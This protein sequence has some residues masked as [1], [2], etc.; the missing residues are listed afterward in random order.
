MGLSIGSSVSGGVED[1]LYAR[2]WMNETSGQWGMGV[3]IKTRTAYGGY[4]RNI[5]YEDNYFETA[6]VPGGAIHIESGYQSGHGTCAFDDCTDIRDIVF[7]NLTFKKSG[8]TGNFVCFPN[9]PCHNITFDNVHVESATSGWGCND[10]ASGSFTD[11]TPPR[12]PTKG[13]C[14]FTSV[15]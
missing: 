7:R 9:R 4:I 14:N 5:V 2:N 12:D 3:H 13:N 11:V 8:G 6:G 10:I 1:V 15:A